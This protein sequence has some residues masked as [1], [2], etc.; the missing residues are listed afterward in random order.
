MMRAEAALAGR[1][2]EAT[3]SASKPANQKR[4][5]ISKGRLPPEA[6]VAIGAHI[7]LIESA[8]AHMAVGKEQIAAFGHE[9]E[10][11]VRRLMA[12]PTAI[13]LGVSVFSAVF[14]I[15]TLRDGSIGDDHPVGKPG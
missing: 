7:H 12:F 15:G 8:P 1:G 9:V 6:R 2:D 13:D 14:L 3:T 5:G 11:E 10:A 4:I